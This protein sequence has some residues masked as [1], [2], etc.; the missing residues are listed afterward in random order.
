[1]A[2]NGREGHD[3]GETDKLEM[4]ER[5]DEVKGGGKRWGWSCEEVKREEVGSKKRRM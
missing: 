3:T 4:K 1:M 2:E 5:K